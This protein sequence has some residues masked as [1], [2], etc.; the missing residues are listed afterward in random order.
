MNITEIFLLLSLC[1]VLHAMFSP[2]SLYNED[3]FNEPFCFKLPS[4][5][6]TNYRVLRKYSTSEGKGIFPI[7]KI[8][9]FAAI[10]NH[11]QL[12]V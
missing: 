7:W 9:D 6:S 5:L 3:S 1:T 4:V 8:N 10:T 11:V 12:L 2:L